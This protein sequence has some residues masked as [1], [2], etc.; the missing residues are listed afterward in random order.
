MNHEGR[1]DKNVIWPRC[2]NFQPDDITGVI[3]L[4]D[5]HDIDDEM[6]AQK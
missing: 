4:K 5:A 6:D 1:S 2:T 3:E